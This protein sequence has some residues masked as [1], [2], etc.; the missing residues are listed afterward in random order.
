[1]ERNALTKQ[2]AGM[3]NGLSLAF[4]GDSVYEIFVREKLLEHGSL[5]AGKLHERAVLMVRAETQAKVYDLLEPMLDEDERSIL[6]R[7]RNSVVGRIPRNATAAEYRKATGV[8]ALFGWLW[9]SGNESRARDLFHASSGIL[10]GEAF[11]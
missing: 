7:G 2:E 11:V 1:M 8:E 3:L 4:I 10:N 9:L 5:P 6:K